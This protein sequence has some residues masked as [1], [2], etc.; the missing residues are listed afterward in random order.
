VHSKDHYLDTVRNL[1]VNRQGDRRAPHKP[2]LL[3]V[4]IS[5]LLAGEREL[6]FP[7]A[8]E[9]L[10]PLLSA[11]APPVK[12][13]HQPALPYWHLRND[14][15]WEIPGASDIPRQAGNF[16]QMQALR[17]SS[18]HLEKGFAEA[19]ESDHQFLLKTV[20]I[21]LAEHFPESIHS[22][23]LTAVGLNVRQQDTVAD[24]PAVRH[25]R[26]QR[27]PHF[28]QN[29]LRAYEHRCAVTGFRAAL[30][31]QYFGCEAAHVRWH[32]YEG[33]DSVENGFA[34]EPTL[35]KLFDAG[36]WSLAD[37]RR[38]LVS[39]HLTGTDNAVDR[40]RGLH[41]KPLT[42]PLPGEA[43]ISVDYIWW[44]RKRE[45]GGVFRHPALPL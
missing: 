1:N 23:I 21:L 4:A 34:V 26:R 10:Q 27:D 36:A 42:P 31:G 28:R 24:R 25:S 32:A 7:D 30:G 13:R 5:K 29:V 19:L 2:L 8:E 17:S 39:A 3:L 40:V 43:E 45:L 6:P 37:D 44:H 20:G 38:I 33:P 11:Y 12:A 14:R 22:D 18:G 15:L 9:L 16:P 35:H 41:G